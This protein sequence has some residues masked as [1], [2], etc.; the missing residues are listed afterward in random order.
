MSLSCAEVAAVAFRLGTAL[1]LCPI[2]F[3]AR[4]AATSHTFSSLSAPAEIMSLLLLGAGHITQIK[5]KPGAATML[6]QQLITMT[7]KLQHENVALPA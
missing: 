5:Q 3:A 2:G 6:L 4:A 7:E 1:L